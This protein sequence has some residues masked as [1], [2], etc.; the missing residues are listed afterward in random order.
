M[1]NKHKARMHKKYFI[2]RSLFNVHKNWTVYKIIQNYVKSYKAI[3]FVFSLEATEGVFG[4][5]TNI[6]GGAFSDKS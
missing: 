6:Y 5:H 2:I 3:C 1:G 4:T